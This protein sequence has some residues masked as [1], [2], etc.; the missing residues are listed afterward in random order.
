MYNEYE[1]PEIVEIGKAEEVILGEKNI[2]DLD[3]ADGT[4]LRPQAFAEYE[5]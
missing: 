4:F 2:V 1:A 3:T 5:E